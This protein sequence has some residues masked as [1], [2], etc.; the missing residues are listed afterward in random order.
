VGKLPKPAS[1]IG[2]ASRLAAACGT[3][4]SRRTRAV[5]L[6]QAKRGCVEPAAGGDLEFGKDPVEVVANGPV[7]DEQLLPDF[8]VGQPVGRQAGDLELLRRKLIVKPA[9]RGCAARR[10]ELLC[11]G[12]ALADNCPQEASRFRGFRRT[13]RRLPSGPAAGRRWLLIRRSR[14]ARTWRFARRYAPGPSPADDLDDVGTAR[15]G[16]SGRV[17]RPG[18]V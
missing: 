14:R 1:G 4:S 12:S 6:G 18:P 8:S 13:G 3:S 11:G 16:E 10:R 9:N 2:A 15:S 5:R 7:R 17:Q